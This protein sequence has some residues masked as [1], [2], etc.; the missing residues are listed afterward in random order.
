[1]NFLIARSFPFFLSLIAVIG[2]IEVAWMRMGSFFAL[3]IV[4]ILSVFVITW[5]VGVPPEGWPRPE[6]PKAGTRGAH[7]LSPAGWVAVGLGGLSL[8]FAYK[9]AFDNQLVAVLGAILVT[10]L[11]WRPNVRMGVEAPI[12]R[13]WLAFLMFAVMLTGAVFRFYKA[14]EIPAGMLTVDE[15]RLMV[16]AQEIYEGKRET[17]HVYGAEGNATLWVEAAAM[18]LFGETI[19]GFRMSSLIP[20]FMT[21]GLIALLA[22]ELAGARIGLLA[23][24]FTALCYWPVAFSRQEYLVSSSFVPI[25][26][27]PWLMLWGLR[28]G[29]PILLALSGFFLGL[30]FNIYNPSRLVP[31]FMVMLGLFLWM[32]RPTWR[33]ALKL[34]WL[35][36]LGGFV[37][38]LGPLIVWALRD[39]QF[40]FKAYF[41]KMDW[42]LIAGQQVAATSGFF[43]KFETAFGQILPNISKLFTMFTI[44]GGMRP[45]H[46]KLDMPVIDRATLVM[47][48]AGMAACVIRFRQPGFAFMVL[49]W[50]LGLTPTLLAN[51][52]FCM[53]ERRIMLNMPA[54]MMIAGVGLHT[55]LRLLT[56]NFNQRWADAL[57]LAL[58]IAFF[59][60]L[61]AANWRT[62]FHDV[63]L[64]LV[65]Q[66][67]SHPNFDNMTRA[68][69]RAKD[70][71]PVFVISTRRPNDDN[72]FGSN[73]SNELEEHFAI[74]GNRIPRV[75]LAETTY[76]DKGGIFQALRQIPVPKPGAAPYDPLIVLTPFHFYLEPMLLELGGVR[77]ED[78]PIYH[79]L[80][81]PN[82]QDVGL[83]WDDKIATRLIR[84]PHFD[85]A[86]I[87]AIES[88]Y[89][90]GYVVEELLPPAGEP[91]R[92]ALLKQWSFNPEHIAVL[93]RYQKRPQA[94]RVSKKAELRVADPWFWLTANRLS[95]I[96]SVPSRLKGSWVV[97][98][99]A[100]GEYA[101]GAS[102]SLSISMKVAG[103]TVFKRV[104]RD[105]NVDRDEGRE[106]WLG[107]PIFL[108]A[109]DYP[110]E[111]EQVMLTWQG[112]FNQ[113]IRLV[114]R[115]PGGS[116]ETLPLEVLFP[117]AVVAAEKMVSR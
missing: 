76:M 13:R 36:L 79:Y 99:P 78:V 100:D 16:Y 74:L 87:A 12:S 70:K 72:W 85:P 105:G 82:Y 8:T 59:G 40:A 92:E 32:Q 73:P 45:W 61:G 89:S 113:L 3:L 23:G 33:S 93:D 106:G 51:P 84:I 102:S 67:Y 5:G 47:L 98:I 71:G 66:N 41:G 57:S 25:V 58:C 116:K 38:G 96:V 2:L 27:A 9:S 7:P 69:F 50:I 94:W 103:R 109:G 104:P 112:Q 17:F 110:I 65:R 34:A 62:Y 54:T 4:S 114:W 75:L 31:L 29:K 48:M 90:Y 6:E 20:G 49:W 46:L 24:M 21:V 115:K 95:P 56:S 35:P 18:W 22:R 43:S 64:D 42:G 111:V 97:R 37:I 15:P 63:E 44:H 52:E 26:A 39:P 11:L 14:G 88:R 55:C 108:K 30:N 107:E 86:K 101:F 68:I 83:K 91:N 80:L 28:R 19:T 60:T 53:D 81:G 77:V 1:M 117:N 10:A